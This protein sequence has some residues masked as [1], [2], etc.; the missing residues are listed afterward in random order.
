[1]DERPVVKAAALALA[2]HGL[3]GTAARAPAGVW[4]RCACG[5]LVVVCDYSEHLAQVLAAAGLLADG[6]S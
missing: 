6:V 4:V 1:M 2:D 5:R 3:P